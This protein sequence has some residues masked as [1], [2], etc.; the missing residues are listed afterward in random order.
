MTSV[1]SNIIRA[2]TKSPDKYNILCLYF[3]GLFELAL[4]QTGHHF[5]IVF[6]PSN[7]PWLFDTLPPQDNIHFIPS[8]ADVPL[9][10]DFDAVL[11]S[12]RI[13][14]HKN[15]VTLSHIL[16]VP[17]I[18]VDHFDLYL[19]KAE[20]LYLINHNRGRIH[21]CA[22]NIF[23]QIIQFDY[24]SIINYG[25]AQQ[26]TTSN[27]R[28]IDVILVG[29]YPQQQQLIHTIQNTF[30]TVTINANQHPKTLQEIENLFTQ[31]KLYIN[32]YTE[33][34]IPIMM[35]KAM[36]Y[37]CVPVSNERYIA[38][39]II[40]NGYSG[41]LIKNPQDMFEQIK[42]ILSKPDILKQLSTAT[43]SSVQLQFHLP[44]F[45]QQWNGIFSK[46][47]NMVYLG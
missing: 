12:D 33:T 46:L 27:D 21:V 16:H 39:K 44:H 6:D 31:T 7:K 10:V 35:L 17:L 37:G 47:N 18:Y 2:A 29:D 38:S 20:D 32:L 45:V 30:K 40:N 9:H 13:K 15:A 41:I 24:D 23:S 43:T 26:E 4:S 34:N 5:Y 1:I 28:P 42:N 8:I 19:F 14:L 3:D 22:S 11:C 36:S 25:I